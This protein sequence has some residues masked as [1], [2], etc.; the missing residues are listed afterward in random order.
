MD[1]KKKRTWDENNHNTKK[2]TEVLKSLVIH[3]QETTKVPVCK[4]GKKKE[5]K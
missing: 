2:V 3:P 1:T 5:S 4:G